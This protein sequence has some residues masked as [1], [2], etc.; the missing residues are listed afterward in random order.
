[1]G[2]SDIDPV[3]TRWLEVV[4]TTDRAE[5]VHDVCAPDV[6]VH[7]LHEGR[8]GRCDVFRG[9]DAVIEWVRRAPPGRFRFT[10]LRTAAV[11]PL[12]DLPAG[13]RAIAVRFRVE[14]TTDDFSNEGDWV[15]HLAGDRIVALHHAPEAL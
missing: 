13:D 12:P 5:W 7:A 6:L 15:L 10:I 1:M 3:V 9:V 14:H 4:N 8:G 11:E 2:P